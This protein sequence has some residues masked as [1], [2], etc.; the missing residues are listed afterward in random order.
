MKIVETKFMINL[1]GLHNAITIFYI[2]MSRT[3]YNSYY[4]VHYA[5]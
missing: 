4:V 2:Y 5:I 1:G 3:E